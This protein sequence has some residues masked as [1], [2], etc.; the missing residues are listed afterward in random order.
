M[1]FRSA[2]LILLAEVLQL[3]LSISDGQMRLITVITA[4]I[5]GL[6]ILLRVCR[7]L[8]WKRTSLLAAMAALFAA[9]ATIFAQLLRFPP[10]ELL[11]ILII[12]GLSA[13]AWPILHSLR[14]VGIWLSDVL[15]RLFKSDR[16]V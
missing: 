2:I 14:K 4:G 11:T 3:I 5:A 9:Q 6:L 13:L 12:A 16:D 10:P 7:P 8:N 15:S 1:L